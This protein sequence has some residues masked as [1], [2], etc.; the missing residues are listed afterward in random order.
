MTC[1]AVP[2]VMLQVFMMIYRLVRVEDFVRYKYDDNTRE[3]VRDENGDKVVEYDNR[4]TVENDFIGILGI[5]L[6]FFSTNYSVAAFFL[7]KH[8][9]KEATLKDSA[10]LLA[11]EMATI[12]AQPVMLVIAML[13]FFI[14]M[15]GF[16]ALIVI[17]INL[18]MMIITMNVYSQRNTNCFAYLATFFELFHFDVL[19]NNTSGD[20]TSLKEE[21]TKRVHIKSIKALV[22]SVWLIVIVT[23]MLHF[24][25]IT[26][27]TKEFYDF[28]QEKWVAKDISSRLWPLFGY[29]VASLSLSIVVNLAEVVQY[30]CTGTTWIDWIFNRSVLISDNH[31]H[32]D[33]EGG[34]QIELTS[35]GQDAE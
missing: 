17:A 3:Y 5:F 13:L 10:K 29:V 20:K 12:I 26:N 15:D 1:E 18:G 32:H 19:F 2:Q 6:G 34:E 4:I 33:E 28:D 8:L 24:D 25:L 27:L 11:I 16:I 7:D 21:Q 23:V 31:S 30:L 35:V 9:E 14:L 22:R